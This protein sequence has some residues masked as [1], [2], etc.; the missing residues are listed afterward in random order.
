MVRCDNSGRRSSL[1][2]RLKILSV[3]I[4]RFVHLR[5]AED[6]SE[7]ANSDQKAA[8]SSLLLGA[9]IGYWL[10]ALLRRA[11]WLATIS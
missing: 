10:R 9:R 3:S 11:P 7:K 4:L 2:S 6:G 8:I 5:K 1:K